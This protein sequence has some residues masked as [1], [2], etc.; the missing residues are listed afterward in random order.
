MPPPEVFTA[1][2]ERVGRCG[3]VSSITCT[4]S[5]VDNLATTLSFIW[6]GPDGTTVDTDN[7]LNLTSDSI[8]TNGVYMCIVCVNVESVGINNLCGIARVTIQDTGQL[9][10]E[11]LIRV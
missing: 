8:L 5:V 3:H 2:P 7:L 6:V 9:Y 11:Q 1:V 4:A 10:V